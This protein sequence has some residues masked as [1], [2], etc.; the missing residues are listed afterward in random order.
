M[1][2]RF[3]KFFIQFPAETEILGNTPLHDITDEELN[4]VME[5]I[6]RGQIIITDE[7]PLKNIREKALN[8]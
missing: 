4:E 3:N 2:L 5:E 1:E 8:T 6:K 7:Y